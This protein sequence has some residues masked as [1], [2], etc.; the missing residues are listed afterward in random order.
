MQA[1]MD[2]GDRAL[3]RARALVAAAEGFEAPVVRSL[4]AIRLLAPLPVPAQMRCAAC[5]EAHVKNALRLSVERR[6]R[7][8]ADPEAARRRM[9]S[10]GE[11]LV[12]R[13][14]YEQPIYYK[15]N[16]FSV[17]GPESDVLWPSYAT[18]LDFELEFGCYLGRVVRDVA[19]DD[20]R[21]AIFGYSVYNDLTARNVQGRA[22]AAHVGPSKDKDFDT[23]NVLG[24]WIVTA[25]ELPDPYDLAMIARLNG[26]EIT[27]GSSSGMYWKFE[28]VIAFVSR[29]ETLYPGEFIGSGAVGNGSGLELGRFL[30]PGDVIELEVEG[31]GVLR[32]RVVK[33]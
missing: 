12:P 30:A 15:T 32:N 19:P 5:F 9:E 23:G 21:R 31:I 26:K 28:D 29:S 3:D 13:A 2:G 24:P 33:P 16:R 6:A 4:D 18:E 20:A 1:L 25:D 11:H 7:H 27:R 22:M 8:E 14:W 17:T 10:E